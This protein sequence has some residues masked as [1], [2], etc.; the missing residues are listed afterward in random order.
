MCLKDR[1]FNSINFIFFILY[2]IYSNIFFYKKGLMDILR[3]NSFNITFFYF[4]IVN[5]KGLHLIYF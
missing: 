1:K 5:K 4:K 3:K 2:I